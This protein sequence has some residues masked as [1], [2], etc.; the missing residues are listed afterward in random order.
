M[1]MMVHRRVMAGLLLASGMLASASAQSPKKVP[2]SWFASDDRF[3]LIVNKD[4]AEPS[5]A[6]GDCNRQKSRPQASLN[7][8]IDP[9]QF[10]DAIAMGKYIIVRWTDSQ[11][12]GNLSVEGLRLNEGG[13]YLWSLLLAVELETLDEWREASRLQLT[14]GLK[15]ADGPGFAWRR[16][17]VMPNDNR[18]KALAAFIRSC[19][20]GAHR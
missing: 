19:S 14:L 3:G 11:A 15:E 2:G 1:G 12:Q 20:S 17:Y 18:K 5:F 7:L 8:R 16:S 13:Q 6:Y 10:A 4:D 9:R